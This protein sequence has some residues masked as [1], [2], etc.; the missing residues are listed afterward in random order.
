MDKIYSD[1]EEAKNTI[2]LITYQTRNS[3]HKYALFAL[4]NFDILDDVILEALSKVAVIEY[5]KAFLRSNI[6]LSEN[7]KSKISTWY[8]EFRTEMLKC[9]DK[10][11]IKIHERFLTQRNQDFAH[12]DEKA[13]SPSWTKTKFGF[14]IPISRNTDYILSKKDFEKIIAFTICQMNHISFD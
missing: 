6:E 7:I 5:C 1:F 4:N 3:A 2:K 8:E 9:L 10:N 12:S 11:D 13:F 14:K